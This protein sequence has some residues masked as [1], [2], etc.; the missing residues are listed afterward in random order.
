M[1]ATTTRP[2]KG[3]TLLLVLLPVTSGVSLFLGLAIGLGTN[4][5]TV[6]VPGPEVTVTAKAAEPEPAPTVTVT[7]EP[8]VVEVTPEV[9]VTAI[10]RG[11]EVI[12]LAGEGF[13]A[14]AEA[15]GAAALFDV[16]GIEAATDRMTEINT[17]VSAI[18]YR[19]AADE[20]LAGA[21]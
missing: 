14:S 17:K 5:Q 8:K 16:A 20:C 1:N 2:R 10:N 4:A 9:C 21:R 18:D 6:T 12:A 3:R 7:P 19:T 11:D 13:D 15:M